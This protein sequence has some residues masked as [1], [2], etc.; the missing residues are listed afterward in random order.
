MTLL[1]LSAL[2]TTAPCLALWLG[3]KGQRHRA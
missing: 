2:V 1:I 3:D